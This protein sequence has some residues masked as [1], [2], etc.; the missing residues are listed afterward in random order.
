ML[1]M[2]AFTLGTVA[3][4]RKIIKFEDFESMMSHKNDQLYLVNFWATW[5]GPCVEELPDFMAV[6]AELADRKD[7]KMI[8]VSLDSKGD[9]TSDVLPFLEE[10]EITTDVYLLDD[11]RRMNYWMPRVNKSWTGSIPATALYR[12]G[13]QL[14]F[15]EKQLHKKELTTLIY[16]YLK[17]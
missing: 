1:L 13:K 10:H 14:H 6:N 12:N 8:L 16:Q 15:V 17:K 2:F 9:W 3:Q 11:H 7:F 4:V 5:C